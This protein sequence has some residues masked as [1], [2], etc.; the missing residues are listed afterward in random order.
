M[1][2]QKFGAFIASRRKENHMTQAELAQKLKVTDKAV[3]RW[4]RGKG[5]P[6]ISILVPLSEALEVSVL[7]LMRS[8][9][10][11]ERNDTFSDD[12]VKN[13]LAHMS[14]MEKRNRREDRLITWISVPVAVI[15]A[16]LAVAS[17]RA[18]ILAAVMFA[19]MAA[20]AVT[21]ACMFLFA[22]R[23][24]DA[25]GRRAYGVCMLIGTAAATV[26]MYLMGIDSLW[27]IGALFL[28]LC[29]AVTAAAR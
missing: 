11:E 20:L 27:L 7:E 24:S 4:E 3:S 8:E 17:G 29:M 1:D 25:A 5:F 22:V 6:D 26:F 28:L 13:M 23:G 21:G 9:K 10:M 19:G 2:A 18:S 15:T 16:F 14:E 12:E